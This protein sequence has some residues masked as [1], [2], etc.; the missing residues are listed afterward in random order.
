MADAGGVQNQAVAPAQPVGAV[1][2]TE[3]T[4][5]EVLALAEASRPIEEERK[6][7]VKR[8]SQS[9]ADLDQFLVDAY[10]KGVAVGKPLTLDQMAAAAT[11]R[12]FGRAGKPI[13][14]Q[15]VAARL[16][17]NG[18][19]LGD[20]DQTALAL[21]TVDQSELVGEV[22]GEDADTTLGG[23]GF[24]AAKSA[25]DTAQDELGTSGGFSTTV[26]DEE[27]RPMRDANAAERAAKKAE[28][29]SSIVGQILNAK[30]EDQL[31]KVAKRF[32]APDSGVTEEELAQLEKVFSGAES[33][34]K[35]GQAKL[36]D[37]LEEA[38]ATLGTEESAEEN[39]QRVLRATKEVV[40]QD[41]RLLNNDAI[42]R[43][44]APVS[45]LWDENRSAG[46]P[47]FAQLPGA[48]KLRWLST[49]AHVDESSP[50]ELAAAVE[51]FENELAKVNF[52]DKAFKPIS[53]AAERSFRAAGTALR[54][55]R[56]NPASD[57]VGDRP[58][59][60][61]GS[62][63]EA[64]AD[65]A[66]P[67]VGDGTRA[68]GV[69][70][71]RKGAKAPKVRDYAHLSGVELTDTIEVDGASTV[72]RMKADEELKRLD[73]LEDDLNAIIACVKGIG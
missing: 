31:N 70:I 55:G 50:T 47:V 20:A 16:Q 22:S 11:E 68:Q 14:R 44:W 67:V 41:L 23:A 45:S 6:A 52:A 24:R 19:K 36:K 46:Q 8:R 58:A 69:K 43:Y 33:A 30:T 10:E 73:K 7:T 42:S 48:A 37:D 21:D 38:R 66:L 28:R 18:I 26:I 54:E 13:S 34:V 29:L 49:L 57:A 71:E 53:E 51:E 62:R 9:S 39:R 32:R 61:V 64:P 72:M 12:G 65:G 25:A 4:D 40:Q 17:K 1:E 3:L 35:S 63:E 60:D 56:H 2:P 27:G 59:D 15:A 5:E